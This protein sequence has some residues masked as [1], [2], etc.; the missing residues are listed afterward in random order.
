MA[1]TKTPVVVTADM[2]DE[3]A[4]LRDQI[5]S[6]TKREKELR[7][8]VRE[9]CGGVDTTYRGRHYVLKTRHVTQERLDTALAREV[10]GEDWCEKHTKTTVSM[11]IDHTEVL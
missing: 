6:L 8:A 10:L 4:A 5:A 1:K 3:L 9:D 2:I 11:N 7:E